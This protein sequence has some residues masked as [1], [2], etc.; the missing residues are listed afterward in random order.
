MKQIK[1]E[2]FKNIPIIDS[3]VLLAE[4]LSFLKKISVLRFN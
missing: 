3:Y 1:Y 4:N 2:L